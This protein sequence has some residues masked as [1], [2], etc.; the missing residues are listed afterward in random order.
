MTWIRLRGLVRTQTG[1]V[2]FITKR[3]GL[4]MEMPKALKNLVTTLSKRMASLT[5]KLQKLLPGKK[6]PKKS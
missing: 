6:T 2:I 3:S 4:L 1:G 5:Q